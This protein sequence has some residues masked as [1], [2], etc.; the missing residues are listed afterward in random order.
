MISGQEWVRN[1]LP[2][3]RMKMESY[4][5]KLFVTLCAAA[6]ILSTA[7]FFSTTPAK[8][9]VYRH[10]V[11]RA[12]VYRSFAH[13]PFYRAHIYRAYAYRP[14]YRRHVY[15]SYAYYRPFYRPYYSYAYYRPF[16]RPYYSYAY[17][18]PYRAYAF[19]SFGPRIWIGGG[20][21]WW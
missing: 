11:Y 13:R 7:A 12:H 1:P 5:R 15:R 14:F 17:Y 3:L 20:R 6:S 10:H 21:R 2:S 19:A 4:M 8:A 18:R 16:Y 9:L